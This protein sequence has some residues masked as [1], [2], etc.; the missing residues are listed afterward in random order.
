M[1]A[2][3]GEL[4]GTFILVFVGCGAVALAVLFG[5]LSLFGVALIFGSGVTLGIYASKK[6]S[7]AHLNP[8]VSLAFTLQRKL[9]FQNLLF[10]TLAQLAGASLG[11]ILIL[12]IFNP[13]IGEFE[14]ANHIVRGDADSYHSAAMFGEFFPNPGFEDTMH[15]LHIEALLY[16]AVGTFL[17]VTAIFHV[18]KIERIIKIPAPILIGCTVMILILFIAPYTQAG[19]NPARDLGPRLIAGVS[20]WAKAAFPEPEYSFLTVYVIGPFI[21]SFFAVLVGRVT[22]G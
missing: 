9:S 1:K 16:E 17:L 13:F 7:P 10:F 19:L 15:V 18:G 22:K 3:A 21:G 8:A 2:F 11:G 12:L 5:A 6:W 4:I 20:G 14:M